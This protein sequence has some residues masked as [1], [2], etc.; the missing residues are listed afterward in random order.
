MIRTTTSQVERFLLGLKLSPQSYANFRRVIITLFEFAKKRGYLPSDHSVALKV[1]RVR[2]VSGDIEIFRH[3]ELRELLAK[4]DSDF[5]PSLAIGAFAGLRSAEIEKLDWKDVQLERGWIQVR[6]Q[7]AKTA[8]RRLVPIATNLALWLAPHAKTEGSV[9]PFGHDAFYDAQQDTASN[10]ATETGSAMK[11]KK[12]ALRH[13]YISYRLA[14]VQNEN[15][16]A[17]ESGNSPGMIHHHYKQLVTQE[18]G[19]KWFEI[20]PA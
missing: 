9:W 2:V 13:S 20:K 14:L 10:T 7:K 1:D 8:S 18:E 6:P 17:L 5:L 16:V 4:A 11:W 19:R 3:A 15:Q 12:N